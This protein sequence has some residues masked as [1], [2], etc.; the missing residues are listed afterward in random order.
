MT[1]RLPKYWRKCTYCWNFSLCFGGK[2]TARTLSSALFCFIATEVTCGYYSSQYSVSSWIL[3]YYYC[4]SCK[5]TATRMWSV[6]DSKSIHF[7]YIFFIVYHVSEISPMPISLMRKNDSSSNI[8]YFRLWTFHV[9]IRNVESA[10]LFLRWLL[11]FF[12]FFSNMKWSMQLQF[13]WNARRYCQL[14]SQNT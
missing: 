10:M 7:C 14:L 9:M 6:V 11:L 5:S 4:R 12:T 1:K 13:F 8:L 3:S 2:Y